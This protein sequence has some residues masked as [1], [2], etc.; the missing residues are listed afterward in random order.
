MRTT[1]EW[2]ASVERRGATEGQRDLF[3]SDPVTAVNLRR[4]TVDGADLGRFSS[5]GWRARVTGA[6]QDFFRFEYPVVES[7]GLGDLAR[8]DNRSAVEGAIARAGADETVSGL[9]RG[10]DTRLGPTWEGGVD[11]SHGQWQRIALA[12]GFMRDKPLLMVLDEPTSA[13]D[14]ETEHVLFERY[15]TA[16][17]GHGAD[18]A[19][20]ITVL[21]SHRFST[22]GMADLIAVID[23][24]RVVEHGSHTR[25]MALK[26][27]Y[28]ELYGLQAASYR[29]GAT[30]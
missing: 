8:I 3:D 25:L 23:G 16:A 18:A 10:V 6:F 24:A 22:V 19:S 20:Q 1:V 26:G 9:E 4:I 5:D 30:V 27:L 12:R 14:A 11:L 17:R 28:A 15:A 2:F 29:D 7:V 21:I 13:L